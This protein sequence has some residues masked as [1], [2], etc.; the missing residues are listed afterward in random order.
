METHKQFFC[1]SFQRLDTIKICKHS[2]LDKRKSEKYVL[3]N[4]LQKGHR[5]VI[6]EPI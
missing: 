3:K 5:V 4:I 1:K 6:P 2:V